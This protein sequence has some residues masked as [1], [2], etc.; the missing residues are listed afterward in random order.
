VGQHLSRRLDLALLL[1]CCY[2]VVTLLSHCCYTV[3][4]MLLHCRYTS[5]TLAPGLSP[6][7][8]REP[9]VAHCLLRC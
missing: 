2:T 7:S 9:P 6:P 8:C 3:V 1:H 5:V 4:T